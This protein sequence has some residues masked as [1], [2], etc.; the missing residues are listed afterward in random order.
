M[1]LLTSFFYPK[2]EERE[3]ELIYTLTQN[4]NK[5]F[6]NKINLYITENDYEKF[7]KSVFKD[8]MNYN[9]IKFIIK[10]HQPAY[11][12]LIELASSFDNKIICICNSD[13]EFDIK[14]INIL[15]KLKEN[16]CFFI[17]RHEY[18][19][20]KLLIDN[21]SRFPGSSDAFIFNSNILRKNIENQDLMY[22]NYI[23]N[24]SGIEA[25]LGIFF[26]EQLNYTIYNPC[27]EIKLIHHHKGTYRTYDPSKPIG[28][29]SQYRVPGRNIIWSKYLFHP[30][31]LLS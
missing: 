5:S 9:K 16:T 31:K 8:N 1:E 19:N 30:C 23:Q 24:T 28:Y 10:N 2:N 11:K 25:L 21:Y 18:D 26:I 14:N 3:K 27:F 6:I 20:S 4:L 7:I 15:D 29:T 17:T 22:I 13:I 12:E